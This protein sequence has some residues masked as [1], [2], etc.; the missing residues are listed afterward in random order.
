MTDVNEVEQDLFDD[1]QEEF[2]GKED[3]K[4]RLVLIWVTGRH[5]VR[6]SADA[7]SRPYD[8]YETVT[9][10]LDDGPN[11]DG[12]KVV[13]GERKP[14]LVASVKDEGPQRLDNFQFTQS[15]L[16][17]RL[18]GRVA[19]SPGSP[20]INGPA[21]QDKSKTYRPMI[22]RINSRPNKVKGRSASW[23]IA[24]PTIEDKVVARK[25]NA[26]IA[27][28]SK[29]METAGQEKAENDGFDE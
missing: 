4:D 20:T 23:S 21:V 16:T 22:G 17:T 8:W 5:G 12:F 3:L 28:I 2:P 27:Q 10:V 24:E 13:D 19:L 25:H 15:G 26:L 6:K 1:A 29:E 14:M 7:G 11:W 18:A 9:V